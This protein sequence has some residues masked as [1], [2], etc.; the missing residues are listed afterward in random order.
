VA[1]ARAAGFTP[2]VAA[3]AS[4]SALDARTTRHN[5]YAISQPAR[6]KAEEVFGW[7]KTVAGMRKVK[8]CGKSRV[9]W[10]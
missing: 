1:G 10:T 8:H 2:H 3:K 6:K 9:D 7:M 4:H 5:G